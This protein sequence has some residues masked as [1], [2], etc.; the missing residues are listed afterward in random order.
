M[1]EAG[2]EETEKEISVEAEKSSQEEETALMKQTKAFIDLESEDM[3]HI[4]VNKTETRGTLM[5]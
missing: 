1:D 4:S 2:Y 3:S 5:S